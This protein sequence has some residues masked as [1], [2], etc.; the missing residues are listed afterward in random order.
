MN[1]N[2]ELLLRAAILGIGGSALIDLWS[3]VLQRGFHISTLDYR[4]LGRWIGH[5][6]RGKFAHGR[7]SAA[8]AVRGERALGWMA[9]YTIGVAFA[10]VLLVLAGRAWADSPTLGPALLLGIG[11][12]AAPWLVMQPAF[13]AG[14]A[15]AKTARPWAGRLR[16]L[17]THTVYGLGLYVTALAVAAI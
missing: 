11:T 2:A 4:M 3:L 9:H 13:G 5:M 12:V 8:G 1:T 17:G 10:A 16:N 14:F 15:G 6:R 7:I